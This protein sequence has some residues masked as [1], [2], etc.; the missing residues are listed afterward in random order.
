MS[1]E[2]KN[3]LVTMFKEI[4][5]V[6]SENHMKPINTFCAQNTELLIVKA[7]GMCSYHWYTT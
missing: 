1:P 6:N 3:K 5:I 4:I 7:G 2:Y